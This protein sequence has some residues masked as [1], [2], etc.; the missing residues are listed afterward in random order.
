MRA[1]NVGL[2]FQ[3]RVI[4]AADMGICDYKISLFPYD[5]VADVLLYLFVV[6]AYPHVQRLLISFHIY[7]YRRLMKFYHSRCPIE[8]ALSGAT[9]IRRSF[10]FRLYAQSAGGFTRCLIPPRWYLPP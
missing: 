6:F 4:S 7:Q 3:G 5:F 9:R 2:Y 8:L 10:G 1:R